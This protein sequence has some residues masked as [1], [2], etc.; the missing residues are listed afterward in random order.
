MQDTPEFMHNGVEPNE[1]VLPVT[2]N[3]NTETLNED[4]QQAHESE[5]L[6][7][8]KKRHRKKKR[9]QR[10]SIPELPWTRLGHSLKQSNPTRQTP[11]RQDKNLVTFRGDVYEVVKI[12][13][14]VLAFNNM[15]G[16]KFIH[17]APQV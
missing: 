1:E 3:H 5:G 4:A 11:S 10:H 15:K 8:K 9:R 13:S 16:R 14:K 17:K 2:L 6:A 12:G 7:T